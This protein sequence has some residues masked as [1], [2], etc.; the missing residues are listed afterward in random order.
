MP[1]IAER[2]APRAFDQDQPAEGFHGLGGPAAVF[3]REKLVEHFFGGSHVSAAEAKLCGL[4]RSETT[5][6]H[7]SL[8][9]E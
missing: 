4:R 5:Q 7:L 3:C 9:M 1:K 6:D 2:R 8:S